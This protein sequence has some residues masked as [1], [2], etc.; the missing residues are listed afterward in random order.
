MRVFT[1]RLKPN[2]SGCRNGWSATD[3]LIFQARSPAPAANAGIHLDEMNAPTHDPAPGPGDNSFAARAGAADV[4][5]RLA[6]GGPTWK[7]RH[8]TSVGFPPQTPRRELRQKLATLKPTFFSVTFRRR[9]STGTTFDT[10]AGVTPCRTTSHHQLDPGGDP[11]N[12]QLLRYSASAHRRPCAICH[13][14]WPNRANYATPTSCGGSS[15]PRDQRLVRDQ[16]VAAYPEI[17][18]AVEEPRDDLLQLQACHK[19]RARA[20]TAIT[21]SSNATTPRAFRRQYASDDPIFPASCH[22]QLRQARALRRC[23]RRG[24]HTAGCAGGPKHGDDTASIRAYASTSSPSFASARSRGI[25]LPLHALN[26]AKR[27]WKSPSAWRCH[28]SKPG[29]AAAPRTVVESQPP[30]T[31]AR[32]S[33]ALPGHGDSGGVGVPDGG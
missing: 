15:T 12:S 13:R 29:E 31:S 33:A 2:S 23:L 17:T 16:R 21:S 25:D 8:Q 30:V 24:F 32:S 11:R 22:R 9:R 19:G 28:S 18:T 26:Q 5:I 14:A 6:Q 10:V 27:R 1:L 3:Q 4:L 7:R 20:P